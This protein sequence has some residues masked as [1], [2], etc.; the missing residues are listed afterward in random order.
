[1]STYMNKLNS[2]FTFLGGTM[3]LSKPFAFTQMD[4]T[5]QTAQGQQLP[6]VSNRMDN[7]YGDL[8]PL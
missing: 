6:F 8:Q 3:A 4:R 2:G 7:G 5:M 1:M